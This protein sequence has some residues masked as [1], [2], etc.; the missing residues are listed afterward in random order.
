MP[1]IPE[2]SVANQM[3]RF[4]SVSSDRNIRDHLR[5]WSAYFGRNIPDRNSPF[6]FWQ[7]GSLPLLGNSVTKFKMTRAIS[8]GRPDLIGKCHSIFLRYST[9]LISDWS[10]RHNGKDP[11]YVPCQEESGVYYSRP[12][13]EARCC[14]T[15]A[16]R[17]M[18]HGGCVIVIGKY[19]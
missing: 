3:E 2:I 18:H 10:L 11:L 8:I 16:L 15:C 5:R 19:F 6:H 17:T 14:C 4:V 9:A 13:V 7:T 1:Q 12:Q